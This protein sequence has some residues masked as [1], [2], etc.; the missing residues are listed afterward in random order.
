MFSA[1]AFGICVGSGC[2]GKTPTEPGGPTQSP[3]SLKLTGPDYLF[4]SESGEYKLEATYADGRREPMTAASWGCDNPAAI[5]VANGHATAMASG[6]ATVFSDC[7]H[8]RATQYVRVVP[9]YRGNWSGAYT[10]R[11]CAASGVFD[12]I[13]ACDLIPNGTELPIMV[14]LSQTK[15]QT[16]GTIALGDLMGDVSGVVDVPGRLALRGSMRYDLE[17][18][19]ATV[20]LNGWD[21]MAEGETMS[22]T[23][24]QV[25]TISGASGS[26]TAECQVRS[27]SRTSRT[28][29][30]FANRSASPARGLRDLLMR[31]GAR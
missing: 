23:F 13:H 6:G 3:A 30:G 19:T 27:V 26:M 24:G 11:S 20:T 12:A 17:G 29:Q 4:I 21:T 15:D 2:G 7:Q 31:L 10:W 22:G 18:M 25:W 16:T 28:V 9:D 8:G 1:I 5:Q 14:R